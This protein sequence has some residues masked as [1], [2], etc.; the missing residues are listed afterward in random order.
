MFFVTETTARRRFKDLLGQ[1]NHFLITILVGLNG[2]EKGLV[3]A[4]ADFHAAWNPQ[5]KFASARRSRAFALDLGLVRSID[6]LDAY[7]T[8]CNR[9]PTAIF[10]D[11][12]RGEMDSAG[13]SVWNKL[14]VFCSFLPGADPWL[15]ALVRSALAWRNQRVHSLDQDKIIATDRRILL[16]NEV[17]IAN[18]FRGLRVR[19]FL[20][21]FDAH[22]GPAFKETAGFIDAVHKIVQHFDGELIRR[23]DPVTLL[24]QLLRKELC[25]D[26]VKAELVDKHIMQRAVR[27]W[28]KE[29]RKSQRIESLLRTL[30][31]SL[32]DS[33]GYGTSIPDTVITELFAFSP[34]AAVEFVNSE[35]SAG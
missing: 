11:R 3:V 15:V 25:S 17:G 5:D 27:I 19:E 30:G 31:F 24:K 13:R 23:L 26:E 22:R 35:S 18:Q 20:D 8:L 16:N 33:H 4:D 34:R 32:I 29:Q 9:K 1:A 7:M 14:E 12:F 28:G 6:A 10:E 21:N 2:I